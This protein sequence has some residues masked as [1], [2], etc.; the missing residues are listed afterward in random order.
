MSQCFSSIINFDLGIVSNPLLQKGDGLSRVYKEVASM[1]P[2]WIK[3][4]HMNREIL[5]GT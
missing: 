4:Y 3:K 2:L 5:R 1:F